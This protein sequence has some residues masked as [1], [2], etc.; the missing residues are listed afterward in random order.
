MKTH[1]LHNIYFIGIGGI[2]MSALARF[3]LASG[4]KVSGY[5]KTPSAITDELQK[6]GAVIHFDDEV[7]NIP[8]E[9]RKSTEGVLV[10]WTPAVPEDHHE[11]NWFRSENYKL[12]KRA[13]VLGL[14]TDDAHTIA[15]AGTH[16]KTTTTTLTAHLLRTGGIDCSAFLGGV[17]GNYHTNLLLGK[18][19]SDEKIPAI[20]KIVVAEADEFDRSFLWLHPAVAII[21]SVDADHLD[22]YND[23]SA[24]YDSYRQF[25]GQV[26]EKVIAKKTVIEKLG[27]VKTKVLSYSLDSNATDSYAENIRI[28]NGKYYFDMNCCGDRLEDLSLGL[29]GRHNVENAV[30]AVSAAKQAGVKNEAV[31]EALSSFKGVARR[32]DYRFVNEKVVYIDDYGHHPAELEA[33]IS[34]AQELFP[35]KKIT[36]V[37]QPHLFSRT[38]D[39]AGEFASALSKLDDVILLE[40]YPAREKPIAGINSSFLLSLIKTKKKNLYTKEELVEKTMQHDFDVLITMGAGDIDRFVE[41]F[42]N[43]LRRK[44]NTEAT[45][46]KEN[47]K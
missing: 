14:I 10:V 38:K 42:E 39:F 29:P 9:I 36:A 35:G 24:M 26:K 4:K 13:Q 47:T 19:I 45:S 40:I 31:R 23:A 33:C 34:S 32:F 18:N 2:G 6:E 12:M 30:A 46:R 17:S 3:F 1:H 43:A 44:F 28:R 16:G 37:F 41:P 22:I 8:E 21:T 11:L 20:E 15:I 25:A 5:D 7:K 27:L